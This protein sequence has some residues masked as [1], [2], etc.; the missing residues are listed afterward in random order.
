MKKEIGYQSFLEILAI[1]AAFNVL[2]GLK[3]FRKEGCNLKV[4]HV[5][6]LTD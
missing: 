3:V 4:Y 1:A 2:A 6:K 5:L